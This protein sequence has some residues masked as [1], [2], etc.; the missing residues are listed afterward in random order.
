MATFSG[1]MSTTARS[2]AHA[3]SAEAVTVPAYTAITVSAVA[4]SDFCPLA[5][6]SAS[7]TRPSSAEWGSRSLSQPIQSMPGAGSRSSRKRSP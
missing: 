6:R 5:T 4:W 3:S 1:R 7:R 2:S